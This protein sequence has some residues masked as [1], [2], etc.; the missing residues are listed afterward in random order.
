MAQTEQVDHPTHYNENPS[1]VECIEIIR[2]MPHNVG[3]AIKYIWRAGAKVHEGETPEEAQIRDYEK[4]I[5][6]LQDQ[7]K[8]VRGDFKK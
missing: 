8:L 7:I 3:A 2:H 4:A 1:G 6:Y 5:W